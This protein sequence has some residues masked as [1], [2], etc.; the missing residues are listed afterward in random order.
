[1]NTPDNLQFIAESEEDWY[2]PAQY[3]ASTLHFASI[4]L[5]KGKLGAGK[6]TFVRKFLTIMQTK[7]TVSSPTFSVMN[8]YL[9]SMGEVYHFD[10]YRI[11]KQNELDEIGFW[12]YLHA[13]NICLIEWPEIATIEN[14]NLQYTELDF[15]TQAN[16][17]RTLNIRHRIP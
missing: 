16:N 2:P 7:D 5:L 1:M 9:C 6:T 11:N 12:D 14:L 8:T 10:L 13:G 15:N 3:L 4:I 17:I